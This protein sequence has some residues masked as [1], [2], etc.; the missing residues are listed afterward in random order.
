[1]KQAKFVV[2][3]EVT[4]PARLSKRRVAELVEKLIGCGFTD[5]EA[6]Q[7]DLPEKDWDEDIHDA[8]DMSLDGVKTLAKEKLDGSGQRGQLAE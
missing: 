4:A 1:M 5:L 2:R 7:D 3:V 6:T 8:S